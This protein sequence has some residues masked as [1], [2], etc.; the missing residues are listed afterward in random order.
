MLYV[1]H[2]VILLWS[3]SSKAARVEYIESGLDVFDL[4]EDH[5]N[6]FLPIH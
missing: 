1:L 4:W 3:K 2:T 5:Y 6:Y